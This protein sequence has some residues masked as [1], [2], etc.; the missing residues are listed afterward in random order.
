MKQL[1]NIETKNQFTPE[2]SIQLTG[3]LMRMNE[4]I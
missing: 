4:F 1:Q 2:S 3:H